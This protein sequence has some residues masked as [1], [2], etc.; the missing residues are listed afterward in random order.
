VDLKPD[1]DFP[2]T[3]TALDHDRSTLS[4]LCKK[5]SGPSI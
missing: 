1:D 5:R 3:G 4:R 2:L